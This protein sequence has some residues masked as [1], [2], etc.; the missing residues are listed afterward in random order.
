MYRFDTANGYSIESIEEVENR[1]SPVGGVAGAARGCAEGGSESFLIIAKINPLEG[2][3]G[4][5]SPMS[6]GSATPRA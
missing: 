3:G 1:R 2:E 5:P 4:S 6:Q